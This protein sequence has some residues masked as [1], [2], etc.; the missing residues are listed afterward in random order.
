M[1]IACPA[2]LFRLYELVIPMTTY[3]PTVNMN[4]R[5]EG[6]SMS[7][8]FSVSRCSP[9]ELLSRFPGYAMPPVNVLE[10]ARGSGV[11]VYATEFSEA[12]GEDVSGSIEIEDG[13]PV[14]YVNQEHSETRQRFTIA[15]ELGHWF[16]GHLT[17]E[18]GK[19]I[20]NAKRKRSAKW[21]VN[22]REAN[23]FAAE[24]LMPSRLLKLAIESGIKRHNDL[25][26][27]FHVSQEAMSYRLQN[28]RGVL[29]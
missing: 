2:F 3:S 4:P 18:D 11:E 16:C 13:N 20:D 25:A 17:G 7:I 9:I 26:V 29:F 22:E 10:I 8:A 28:V 19:I 27:L 15:H 23:Q 1:R 12:D 24:L 5:G 21:D 14:I 6:R